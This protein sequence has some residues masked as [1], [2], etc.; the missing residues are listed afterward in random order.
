MH[1]RAKEFEPFA[2]TIDTNGLLVMVEA[3]SWEQP[4]SSTTIQELSEEKHK[5]A[6]AVSFSNG[7]IPKYVEVIKA[8][9]N[10]YAS[11]GY[12]RSRSCMTEVYKFLIVQGAIRKEHD[13]YH[14]NADFE[15]AEI[16]DGK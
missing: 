2:I 13:G 3:Y 10:V 16:A 15:L 12:Q 1:M 4:R 9:I 5:E 6:L 14:Y 7:V 8:L 11:I